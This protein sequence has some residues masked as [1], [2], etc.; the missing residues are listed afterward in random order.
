M[1]AMSCVGMVRYA[2]E[3]AFSFVLL[4]SK[5]HLSSLGQICQQIQCNTEAV[6]N[7]ANVAG[8]LICS[9]GK[10]VMFEV[11]PFQKSFIQMLC[12]CMFS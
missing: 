7:G 11:E 5:S 6:L 4:H 12:N 3:N 9:Q 2:F 8:N 1:L 10:M